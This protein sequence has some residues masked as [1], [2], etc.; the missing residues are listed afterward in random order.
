VPPQDRP[1]VKKKIFPHLF[2]VF[3][4]KEQFFFVF[5][6]MQRQRG[7]PSRQQH[8]QQTQPTLFPWARP[9]IQW[10]PLQTLKGTLMMVTM[11]RNGFTGE[12]HP[13]LGNE[14]LCLCRLLSPSLQFFRYILF[15][16]F[17][18]LSD[19]V[20]HE[21]GGEKKQNKTQKQNEKQTRTMKGRREPRINEVLRYHECHGGV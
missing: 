6:F 13:P 3:Q 7:I 18:L 1:L 2:D 4:Q 9:Q 21:S 14:L 17:L 15:F 8:Q 20:L 12:S 10:R 11:T 16:F 5:F 19:E